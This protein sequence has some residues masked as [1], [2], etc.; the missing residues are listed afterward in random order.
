MISKCLLQTDGYHVVFNLQHLDTT[1]NYIDTIIEFILD[2]V[3]SEISLKS[4]PTLIA[5]SDWQELIAYFEQHIICL[6]QNPS[7]QSDP[8]V[9]RELGFQIKA[10]SGEIISLNEG[11]FSLLF[12]INAGRSH[13]DVSST[14]IGGESAITLENLQNFLSSIRTTL[15]LLKQNKL[16]RI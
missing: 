9:P 5:L 14:Y 12:M 10:L 8:F 4:I 15:D 6:Q 2:P 16:I 13:E 1:K 7:Y 3:I 11:E